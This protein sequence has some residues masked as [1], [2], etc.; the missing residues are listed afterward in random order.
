MSWKEH[1]Q[2]VSQLQV[3]TAEEQGE[4]MK[5]DLVLTLHEEA[6]I[7]LNAALIKQMTT[8]ELVKLWKVTSIPCQQP[9]SQS[10]PATSVALTMHAQSVIVMHSST[11]GHS[12]L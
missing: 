3:P 5:D 7:T 12:R 2:W 11:W 4:G 9:P 1:G 8:V 6:P 10:P